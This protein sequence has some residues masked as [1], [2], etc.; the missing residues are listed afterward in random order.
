MP[1]TGKGRL[2]DDITLGDK[3]VLFDGDAEE[4][5][6]MTEW[7]C[8]EFCGLFICC[9][10]VYAIWPV[11]SGEITAVGRQSPYLCSSDK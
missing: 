4:G 5:W 8:V 9:D 7:S 10:T 3:R 2:L 11:V 1:H 6:F